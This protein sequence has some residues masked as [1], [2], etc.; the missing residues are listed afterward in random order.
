MAYNRPHI[1]KIVKEC[2]NL[3]VI[4]TSKDRGELEIGLQIR[5]DQDFVIKPNEEAT[6]D[7]VKNLLKKLKVTLDPRKVSHLIH[8]QGY[9]YGITTTAFF[10]FDAKLRAISLNSYGLVDSVKE[11]IKFGLLEYIKREKETQ[12]KPIFTTETRQ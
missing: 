10:D 8:T 4:I 9:V 12:T 1:D 2:G 6:Y 11:H 5:Q 7:V 3:N